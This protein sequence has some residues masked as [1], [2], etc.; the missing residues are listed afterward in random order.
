MP[1]K[2]GKERRCIL[3]GE[4]LPAQRLVRFVAGPDGALVPDLAEKLPGRGL[5][6]EAR[7][8]VFEK[9]A[10]KGLFSRAARQSVSLPDGLADLTGKLLEKRALES[11][12]LAR[13]AGALI[14]GLDKVLELI[15][16][17]RVFAIVEA[18]DAGADGKR[19]LRARLKAA[20]R[21]DLPVVTGPGAEQFGLAL[22]R[23]NVIHA[24]LT[25]GRMAEKVLADLARWTMWEPVEGSGG[26]GSE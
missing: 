13:R 12:S 24:A 26:K 22:G 23:P 1:A 8:E 18:A 4:V 11:L 14:S 2:A 16:K 19:R 3:S 17:G 25:D 21:R 5:W 7:R 6:V 15:G 10:K 9:A 20:E